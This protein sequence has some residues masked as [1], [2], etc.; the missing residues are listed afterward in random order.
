[1]CVRQKAVRMK[2]SLAFVI[3][4]ALAGNMQAQDATA[5][6]VEVPD[7]SREKLIQIL[8]NTPV[9]EPAEPRIQFGTGFV[10]FRALRMRW[11]LAYVPLMALPGSIPWQY[12]GAMGAIPDPFELTH[13]EI[14]SPPRTWRQ[15][16]DMNAELRRIERSERAK[17]KVV[18]KPE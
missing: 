1:M 3:V 7:Y 10:D 17:A 5:P 18:A 4:L 12:N 8:A 11:R 6:T 16:R 15:L 14:A 2:Y 9:P 13:T